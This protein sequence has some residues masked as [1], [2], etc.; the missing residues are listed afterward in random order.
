MIGGYAPLET[1]I[2]YEI[3]GGAGTVTVADMDCSSQYRTLKALA[4]GDRDPKTGQC[5]R[6]STVLKVEAVPAF[7][8][9]QP[10][11]TKTAAAK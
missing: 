2:Q 6:I 4:D 3:Y 1:F 7:V 11:G 9:D 5:N 8:F 10:A